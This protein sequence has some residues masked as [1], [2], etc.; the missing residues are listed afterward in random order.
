MFVNELHCNV[1]FQNGATFVAPK[2]MHGGRQFENLAT[3]IKMQLIGI[4]VTGN[5]NFGYH[6]EVI[7]SFG[8]KY[9]GEYM[10]GFDPK[11]FSDF[12]ISY[13]IPKFI[14]KAGGIAMVNAYVTISSD[15]KQ[16]DFVTPTLEIEFDAVDGGE[17][18]VTE[19]EKEQ[20][21]SLNVLMGQAKQF[22]ED[23]EKIAAN[24]E[25]NVQELEQKAKEYSDELSSMSEEF[26]ETVISADE[27]LE[28][29]A[30]EYKAQMND[31]LIDGRRILNETAATLQNK[32]DYATTLKGYG[33]KDA[34]TKSETDIMLLEK[35]NI[36]GVYTKAEIDNALTSGMQELLKNEEGVFEEYIY[37]DPLTVT[38]THYWYFEYPEPLTPSAKYKLKIDNY[39]D[40]SEIRNLCVC[41]GDIHHPV[42]QGIDM[43]YE[44]E[45]YTFIET[46]EFSLPDVIKDTDKIFFRFDCVD[47]PGMREVPY[48]LFASKLLPCYNKNQV[49]ELIESKA[50]SS[51]IPTKVS[52]LEN[53]SG[54]LVA[55]DIENKADKNK[56]LDYISYEIVDGYAVITDCDVSISGEYIIPDTIEGYLVTSIDRTAFANCSELTKII[57]PNS[58]ISIGEQAF[59]SCSNLSDITLPEKLTTIPNGAFVDCSKLSQIKIPISV[60]FI[61]KFAFLGTGFN[62]ATV[63]KYG[64][65]YYDGT[66]EQ[67][68]KINIGKGNDKLTTAAIY[69]KYSNVPSPTQN[70]DAANKIYVD[71]MV[72]NIETALDGII[73]LQENLI[74]GDTV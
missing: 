66:K 73:T 50:D 30:T 67:W 64:K 55:A 27:S 38:T 59:S 43:Y 7:D 39:F 6:F 63:I 71:D 4:N 32:A 72:G 47:A 48:T 44:N 11:G 1:T 33:I 2:R 18:P 51:D 58:V 49:D 35:A 5:E 25:D 70:T 54:Y 61:D 41:V 22:K 19:L 29:K 42:L 52:A 21:S 62:P 16:R 69:Y 65:V 13:E 31:M 28:S 60:N 24:V 37:F 12:E 46:V 10:A 53:D 36:N 9:C 14:T 20:Y 56:I 26:K 15:N 74:G 17:L 40:Y 3:V 68:N 57:I 45:T 34:Y 8:N 23:A